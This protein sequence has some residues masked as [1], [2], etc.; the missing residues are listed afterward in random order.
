MVG[1]AS[2]S[3]A[4]LALGLGGEKNSSGLGGETKCRRKIILLGMQDFYSKAL[5][6][7]LGWTPCESCPGIWKKESEKVPGN[8]LKLAVYVG[9]NALTGP[10]QVETI[11]ETEN[12]LKKFP[13]SMIQPGGVFIEGQKFQRWDIL[14]ADLLY[15]RK[16]KTIPP[17]EQILRV[18]EGKCRRK[19][20]PTRSVSPAVRCLIGGAVSGDV[21]W[22]GSTYDKITTNGEPRKVRRGAILY[23]LSSVE[24]IGAAE[25]CLIAYPPPLSRLLTRPHLPSSTR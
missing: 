25:G 6:E 11:R 16:S 12:I 14:G 5:K 1:I 7:D 21:L 8:Y 23:R 17:Q 13:G 4:L 18:W 3:S 24:A 22:D 9:D 20:I 2:G 15:H 19:I 10:D